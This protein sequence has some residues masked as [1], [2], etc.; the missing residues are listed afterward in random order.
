MRIVL[1]GGPGSGKTTLLAALA[2]QGHATAPE[3]G[4]AVIQE[5]L[6]SGGDALP[7]ADRIRFAGRMLEH[8][9]NAWNASAAM[10]GPV[11]FDRGVGDVM[12][13]LDLCGLLTPPGASAAS[14]SID[15]PN[16]P[17]TAPPQG[18][19]RSEFREFSQTGLLAW[20]AAMRCRYHR[21]VFIAP[22]WP[23]IYVNDAERKQD[24]EEAEATC[25]AM[26]RIWPALGYELVWL[27]KAPVAARAAFIFDHLE[28]SG[29]AA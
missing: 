14:G 7:W 28:R 19:E 27:P 25:A 5:Q 16:P 22:V 21:Q 18:Y 24:L 2:Q 20:R 13:Y 29:S 17:A 8:A 23:E 10:A 3:A 11:F 12:G 15:A 9:I 4:R 6:A 26:A 1:T